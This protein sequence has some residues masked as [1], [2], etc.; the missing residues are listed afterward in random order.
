ARHQPPDGA[1]GAGGGQAAGYHHL[2]GAGQPL[3]LFQDGRAEQDRPALPAGPWLPS[4]SSSAI[5]CSRCRGSIPLKGSSSSRTS[6]SCTSAAATLIRWRMPL[7]YVAILR[8]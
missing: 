1:E 6:G 5:M 8:A 2:D 3:D 7:E 4:W